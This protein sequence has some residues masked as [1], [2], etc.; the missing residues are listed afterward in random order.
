[1]TKDSAPATPPVSL[2]IVEDDP[3]QGS[4]LREAFVAEGCHV[5]LLREGD[6]VADWI[7]VNRPTAVL[8]DLGLPDKDGM[9]VCREIRAFSRVP[10][11]MVTARAEEMDRLQGLELG[12]DDYVC[13]PVN[14][15]EVVARLR[16]LLRRAIEWREADAAGTGLVLDASAYAARWQGQPLDLT[17]VEFRLLQALSQRPGHVLSRASL[18]DAMYADHRVVGDRTVDSHVKNLRRKLAEASGGEDPIE[19]VYGMGYRYGV[20]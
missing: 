10:L 1:V 14:V 8:L 13:K 2:L 20:G 9:A 16:A 18:L 15:R 4:L 3:T 6:G 19:S 12:A 5:T 17:P 7:A 11:I